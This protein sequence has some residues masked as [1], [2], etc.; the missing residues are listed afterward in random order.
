MTSLAVAER[1]GASVGYSLHA[2]HQAVGHRRVVREREG[3][4]RQILDA[5]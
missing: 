2:L 1:I 5:I 3:C 4:F